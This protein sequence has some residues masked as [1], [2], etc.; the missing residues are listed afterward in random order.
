MNVIAF[1]QKRVRARKSRDHVCD[2]LM[3]VATRAL[4][5]MAADIREITSRDEDFREQLI[6]VLGQLS[7]IADDL[8]SAS[9]SAQ[10]I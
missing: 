10:S 5:L 9:E 6:F 8:K 3:D 1:P 2:H 7:E 4:D